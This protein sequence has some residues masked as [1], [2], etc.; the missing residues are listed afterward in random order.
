[1]YLCFCYIATV[2][3]LLPH[4][5]WAKILHYPTL[6]KIS[7]TYATIKLW[8]VRINSINRCTTNQENVTQKNIKC[9]LSFYPPLTFWHHVVNMSGCLECCC[10]SVNFPPKYGAIIRVSCQQ[11]LWCVI[12]WFI[13]RHHVV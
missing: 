2:Y 7:F 11:R 4:F 5:L 9:I 10:C 1:M 12:I 3:F 8:N 13:T 6:F